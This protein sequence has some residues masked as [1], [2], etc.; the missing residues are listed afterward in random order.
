M[1]RRKGSRVV[2]KSV[3]TSKKAMGEVRKLRKEG[4]NPAYTNARF[5]SGK[6]KGFDVYAV[7]RKR[8]P[9][10]YKAKKMVMSYI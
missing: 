2:Y 7:A 6:K 5:V 3:P 1:A 10:G 8:T 4:Y 9:K